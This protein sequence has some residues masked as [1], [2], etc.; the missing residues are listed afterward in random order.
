M[1][2]ALYSSIDMKESLQWLKDEVVEISDLGVNH[3]PV[4]VTSG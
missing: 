1:R 4:A 3:F 2:I